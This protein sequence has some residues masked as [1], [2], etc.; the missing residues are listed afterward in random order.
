MKVFNCNQLKEAYAYAASGEVAVHL[1]RIV[2]PSSPSCFKRA[3]AAGYPIAH[4]F[5]QDVQMLIELARRSGVRVV[6]VEHEGTRRQHVD[7]CGQPL[8]HLLSEMGE[9]LEDYKESEH[10]GK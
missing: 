4:I 3:V 10:E 7:L 2:F 6:V 5:A 1:H 8:R 9:D